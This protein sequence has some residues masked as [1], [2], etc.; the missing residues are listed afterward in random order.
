MFTVIVVKGSYMTTPVEDIE[1][2][3]VKE[4]ADPAMALTKELLHIQVEMKHFQQDRKQ[5]W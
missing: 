4:E 5:L 2:C 3:S 1:V